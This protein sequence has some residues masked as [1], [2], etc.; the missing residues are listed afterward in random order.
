MG[1]AGGRGRAA[2]R[3]VPLLDVLRRMRPADRM[4]LLPHF[5][6]QTRDC[7]Y[8]AVVKA[9]SSKVP[10]RSRKRLLQKIKKSGTA[11]P[12]SRSTAKARRDTLVQLGGGPM[13]DLLK[14][15]IPLLLNLFH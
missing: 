6:A 5:D 12:H 9:L 13:G 14:T 7:I 2:H 10:I 11:P 1:K 3:Y 4:I 15:S 8:E